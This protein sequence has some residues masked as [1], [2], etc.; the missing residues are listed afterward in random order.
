MSSV[1]IAF[2]L[3]RQSCCEKEKIRIA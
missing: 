1:N 3:K 2:D